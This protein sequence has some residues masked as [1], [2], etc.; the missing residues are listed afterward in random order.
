[1]KRTL[2]WIGIVVALLLVVVVALPFLVNAN[3][4]RPALESQLSSA[5]GRQVTLG[6]LSLALL[7]GGVEADDLSVSED[8]AFGAMAFLRAKSLQAGVNLMP[9]I[10]SKRLEV[11]SFTVQ[12]PE[13]SLLQNPAGTWNFSSLGQSGADPPPS[14]PAA[15]L[16][17]TESPLDLSVDLVRISGGHV[18]ISGTQKDATPRS[19]EN[20]TL[21]IRDFSRTSVFPFQLDADVVG[22]GQV[23]LDGHAGPIAQQAALSPFDAHL[24]V[25]RLDVAGSGFATPSSGI[26]GLLSLDTT[27]TSSGP[28]IDVKGDASLRDWKFASNGSPA[29]QPVEAQFALNY[30]RATQRGSIDRIPVRIGAAEMDLTGTYNLAGEMPSI[31]AHLTGQDVPLTALQPILPALD[32]VLPAGATIESGKGNV[33]LTSSGSFSA[34]VTTGSI[35]I[36]DAL[37][38]NF[39]LTD[40]LKALQ[41]LAGIKAEAKST[42]QQLVSKFQVTPQGTMVNDLRLAIPSVGEITGSGTISPDHTLDFHT[43]ATVRAQSVL[44]ALGQQ[45]D[46]VTIPLLIQGTSSN[47]SFK[48]DL[49]GVAGDKLDQIKKNP[50]SAIDAAKGVLDLFKKAPKQDTS[51]DDG[52]KK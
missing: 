1:M 32:V 23:H 52:S 50:A 22:G 21:E 44:A 12:D 10:F 40:K 28:K 9:L 41:Q 49:K 26:A 45:G 6:N 13:I 18:T 38:A 7:S 4:F 20:A 34:L 19:F 47:P 36:T 42:I 51:N 8:P 31:D 14:A 2:R 37:L 39:S 48:A 16:A 5:L 30:D 27:A 11:R 17:P 35:D 15:E 24:V 29:Q 25:E 43:R 33:D 3:V 46:T